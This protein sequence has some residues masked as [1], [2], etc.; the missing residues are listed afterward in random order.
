MTTTN[1][2][3]WPSLAAKSAMGQS[4]HFDRRPTTSGLPLETDIVRTATVE[5]C[6]GGSFRSRSEMERYW[7][8]RV[9]RSRRGAFEI[10]A[11]MP[12][13]N[14]V[15]L[16]YQRYD[17]VPVRTHFRFTNKPHRLHVY[18]SGRLKW[19]WNPNCSCFVGYRPGGPEPVEPTLC[20][21]SAFQ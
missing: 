18:Q 19:N 9:E 8:P 12:E 20:P 14:G 5:C 17:G 6:E 7:R 15:T 2:G 16:D 4:R 10:I 11:L 21:R 13:P 3:T 1:S